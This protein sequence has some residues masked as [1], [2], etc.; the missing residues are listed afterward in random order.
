MKYVKRDETI[1][2]VK[3]AMCPMD[4]PSEL[5]DAI[6]RT[7]VSAAESIDIVRCKECKHRIVNEH[8]GEEGNLSPAAT[9]LLDT[10]DPYELSREAWDENWFCADG[11]KKDETD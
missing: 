10:G 2:A 6:A 7:I 5:R 11:E 9:C 3:E 8:A 1:K 4:Y